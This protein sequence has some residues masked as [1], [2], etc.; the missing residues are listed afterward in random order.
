[1]VPNGLS[2]ADQIARMAVRDLGLAW[3][4]LLASNLTREFLG[5]HLAVTMHQDD[6]RFAAVILEDKRLDDD[7]FIDVQIPGRSRGTAMFFIS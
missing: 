7:V 2:A 5:R 1:M 6:Q 3:F 4:D